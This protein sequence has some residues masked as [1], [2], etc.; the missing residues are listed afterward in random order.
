MPFMC[1][2]HASH[3]HMSSHLS[4]LAI[5]EINIVIPKFPLSKLRLREFKLPDQ[6]HEAFQ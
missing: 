1:Q 2:D 5:Y 3:V 6:H 4:L